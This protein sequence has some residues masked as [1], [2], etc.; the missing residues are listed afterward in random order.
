MPTAGKAGTIV[1]IQ[2]GTGSHTTVWNSIF[3][4]LAA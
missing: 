3:S 1:F 2:D 4:S